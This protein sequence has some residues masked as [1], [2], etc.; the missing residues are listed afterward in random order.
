MVEQYRGGIE[1]VEPTGNRCHGSR[2]RER[3]H[4]IVKLGIMES[5]ALYEESEVSK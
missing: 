1:R 3:S 4:Q 5:N 2:Q